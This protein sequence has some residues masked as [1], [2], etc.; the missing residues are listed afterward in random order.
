MHSLPAR[1]S[2]QEGRSRRL[3]DRDTDFTSLSVV[4]VLD[5]LGERVAVGVDLLAH[6]PACPQ[7]HVR[8]PSRSR[9]RTSRRHARV[10]PS[11]FLLCSLPGG[12]CLFGQAGGSQLD[13]T[14]SLLPGD[15]PFGS[16]AGTERHSNE[17]ADE[18]VPGR[19]WRYGYEPRDGDVSLR[20]HIDCQFVAPGSEFTCR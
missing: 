7:P 12:Q 13:S 20:G 15:L 16:G 18:P 1:M 6:P 5:H 17:L 14:A 3:N 8:R 9:K 4:R 2:Y 19:L 11:A 10:A